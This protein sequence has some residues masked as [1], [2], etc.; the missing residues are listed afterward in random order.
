MT[1]EVNLIKFVEEMSSVVTSDP[2]ERHWLHIHRYKQEK[3]AA[4]YYVATQSFLLA[5][6]VFK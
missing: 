5:F 4:N 3:N 6:L 2:Q 1:E